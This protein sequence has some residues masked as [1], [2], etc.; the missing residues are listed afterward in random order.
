MNLEQ[1]PCSGS[2][3]SLFFSCSLNFWKPLSF[4]S[5]LFI[6]YQVENLNLL[7]VNF[8]NVCV[9][10]QIKFFYYYPPEYFLDLC[11]ES[12]NFYQINPGRFEFLKKKEENTSRFWVQEIIWSSDWSQSVWNL[13]VIV[14]QKRWSTSGT[15]FQ[16][17]FLSLNGLDIHR[18][19]KICILLFGR[20]SVLWLRELLAM[21]FWT[22][23]L[24]CLGVPWEFSR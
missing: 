16:M 3:Y 1:R 4:S 7:A 15:F 13:S 5:I 18:L 12:G 20:F 14:K 6:I 21:A 8:L 11:C 17:Y 10:Y 19:S 24:G 2:I 22:G 9:S 23:S